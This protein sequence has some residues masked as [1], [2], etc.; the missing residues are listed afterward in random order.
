MKTIAVV[1]TKGGCG[2]T[3]TAINIAACAG[4]RGEK[5]LLVD[6]DPQGHATLGL[7]LSVEETAGLYEV[8]SRRCELDDI[9]IHD[10]VAGI[11]MVPASSSLQQAEELL[12]DWPRE[13]EL[14]LHLQP[15]RARYRGI[16]L[17]CPAHA[18][19]LATNALLAADEILIPVEMGLF[20]FES[21]QRITTMM[22]DLAIRH[23]CRFNWSILPTMVDQRTRIAR[24]FLRQLWETWPDHILPVLVHNT[25]GV[26]EATSR[27]LPV[28]DYDRNSVATRDYQQLA[29]RMFALPAADVPS[30]RVVSLP[31]AG[32]T[33]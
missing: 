3:T 33:L 2:K 5:I 8:F 23:E 22:E 4:W 13:K 1:N 14:A 10:V 27:G 30:A 18:G 17:D 16:V 6:L 24:R 32:A 26:R 28:I 31:V 19:L 7:N 21:V 25:V 11:D 12:S 9:I 29:A 15:L 20:G